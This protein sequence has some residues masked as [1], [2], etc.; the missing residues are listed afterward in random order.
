MVR[1]EGNVFL[2]VSERSRFD[3]K[4]IQSVIQVASETAGRDLVLQVPVSRCNDPDIS[5]PRSI[6]AHSFVGFLLQGA[7]QFASHSR[8]APPNPVQEP[9]PARRDL[10]A[11]NPVPNRASKC[12]SGVAEEFALIQFR[13]DRSAINLNQGFVFS[14]AA[15]MNFACD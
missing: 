9:G 4:D 6:L 11:T 10:E 1:E 5:A 8:R 13:W 12:P 3:G 2:P 14:P 7:A 15:P